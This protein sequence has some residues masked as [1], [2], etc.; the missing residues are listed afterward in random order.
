MNNW[1]KLPSSAR[2]KSQFIN[3]NLIVYA[4]WVEDTFTCVY[5][6]ED[7]KGTGGILTFTGE[8]ARQLAGHLEQHAHA[9]V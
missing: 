9:I 8:N 2:G 7:T 1:I 5:A 4:G 6:G 3:L